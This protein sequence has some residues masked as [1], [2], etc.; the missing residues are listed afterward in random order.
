ME[1]E[2]VDTWEL[3]IEWWLTGVGR[4]GEW[5]DVGQRYKVAVM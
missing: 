3:R 1:F 4:C 2:V 5:G